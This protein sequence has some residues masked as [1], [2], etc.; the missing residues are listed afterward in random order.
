MRPVCQA[1]SDHL[2]WPAQECDEYP[3]AST[4]KNAKNPAFD[5]STRP[6]ARADNQTGAGY[7]GGWYHSQ[8]ILQGDRFY[9]NV[10]YAWNAASTSCAQGRSTDGVR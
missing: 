10:Q 1:R 3:F 4:A 9:V 7:L 6:I 5:Y 2:G 8:R